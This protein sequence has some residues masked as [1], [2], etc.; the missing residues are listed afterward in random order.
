MIINSTF[1][2]AWWL[3]NPHAQTIYPTLTRRQ[4]VTFDYQERIELPDGDFIDLSWATHGLEST[5]PLVIF[6]HGLGGNTHSSYVAGQLNAYHRH[7][8]RAVFMHFRGASPEPNR[9]A[10]AYHTGET[11][12][13]NYVLE[14]L[15]QR[16]PQT[17]KALVG[18]SLGGN[19]VLKWLGEEPKQ[20]VVTA[21]VAISVPFQLRLVADKVNQGLSRLYQHYLL[22]KLKR[23]FKLKYQ[24]YPNELNAY[25]HAIESSRCFWTF[26]D[27]VTAPLHG[28]AHVHDYYRAA[29]SRQFLTHI[30]I[31]T[32]MIHALDDPFM[33]PA[34]IPEA[35]ELSPTTTLELSRCGGHVGFIAGHVP[36]VP[37][38][39]LDQRV[40][41]FL[42]QYL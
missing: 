40:P 13:L 9:L 20:T 11:R 33:T 31:P 41:T 5:T 1:K 4:S 42:Q 24:Q 39:W 28:F 12:D 10:R 3:K 7:G 27:R 15:V 38:Y 29:S 23:M 18:V 30:T 14:L 17:K 8:W 32:L 16:E 25:W 36:G 37:I 35:H 19:V 21:A 22:Q 34:V 26:D 2:P 6:L